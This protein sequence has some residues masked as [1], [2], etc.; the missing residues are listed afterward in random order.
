[1][2]AD[3]EW[4]SVA[5]LG[6]AAGERFGDHEA[7]VDGGTR[8]SFAALAERGAEAARA[9]AAAGVEPGDRVAFWAPNCHE[10]VIALLGVHQAGAVLVPLNTRLRGTEAADIL[11]RSGSKL[12]C[13]VAGFLGNDYLGMLAGHDLPGLAPPVV[14]RGDAPSGS[15]PWGEFC[16]RASTVPASEID[17]RVAQLG[18]DDLSDVIFT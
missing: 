4:S 16:G 2:R 8:L 11:R 6:S 3:L 15:V 18:P 17:S 5:R 1:M 10:W 12:L 9:F 14:L 7:I 13:T